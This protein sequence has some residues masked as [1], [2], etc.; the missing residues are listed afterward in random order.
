MTTK[1]CR[2]SVQRGYWAVIPA[3][4]ASEVCAD[5]PAAFFFLSIP[6]GAGID[7]C[8]TFRVLYVLVV[9][10]HDRRRVVHFNVTEHPTADWTA[11]QIIQAFPE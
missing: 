9:L 1:S 10:A 2:I 7:C 11:Q 3:G 6:L 5:L 8:A 4:W